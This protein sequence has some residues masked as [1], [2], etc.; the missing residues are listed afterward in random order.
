MDWDDLVQLLGV[1]G[2]IASVIG[3]SVA[4]ASK[5]RT[6]VDSRVQRLANFA[7]A[8]AAWVALVWIGVTLIEPWGPLMTEQEYKTM[9][10]IMLIFPSAASFR[11]FLRRLKSAGG[12]SD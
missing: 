9:L 11:Y 5:T 1:V 7:G 10:A 2:S 3:A 4:I 8:S 6:N 12:Q